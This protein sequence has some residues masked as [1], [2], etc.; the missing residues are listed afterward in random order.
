METDEK[1]LQREKERVAAM[2]RMSEQSLPKLFPPWM[3]R[4]DPYLALEDTNTWLEVFRR[5]RLYKKFHPVLHRFFPR[6]G[7]TFRDSLFYLIPLVFFVVFIFIGWVPCL[8]AMLGLA[9]VPIL[10]Q[11]FRTRKNRGGSF[12]VSLVEV[13]GSQGFH[14]TAITDLWQSGADGRSLLE[15]IYLEKRV[16]GCRFFPL[17]VALLALIILTG[18]LLILH[19][20]VGGL[21]ALLRPHHMLG[22]VL[23]LWSAWE[24]TMVSW[25]SRMDTIFNDTIAPL[26]YM[27]EGKSAV[28]HTFWVGFLQAV[29]WIPIML[30]LILMEVGI[31][32]YLVGVLSVSGAAIPWLVCMNLVVLL[33]I[34][35]LARRAYLAK[36]IRRMEIYRQRADQAFPFFL[37]T[38][39]FEDPDLDKW[40]PGAA[41]SHSA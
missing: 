29:V 39:I 12:P 17:K 18:Y 5:Q 11:A 16:G 15:A 21:V 20:W 28:G 22:V 25:V 40:R 34:S 8:G 33:V 14:V 32:Y 36:L 7:G 27:W 31:W 26:L 2:R 30:F 10:Q 38:Q 19:F 37:A 13:F 3:R 6:S 4:L 41:G 9:L 24:I 35:C 23:V 1:A